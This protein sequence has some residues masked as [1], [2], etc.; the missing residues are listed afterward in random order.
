MS[1][2]KDR[3][4]RGPVWVA[5]STH[6]HKELVAISNLERQGYDVY[7]PMIRRRIRH[8]RRLQEVLRPL[9]PGYVFIQL[10][11]ERDHWRTVLSTIGVKA[12]IRFGNRL[13]IV[14]RGFVEML[15]DHEEDGAVSPPPA[16]E[17]YQPGERVRLREGPFEGL[18]GTV[19]RSDDCDRLTLLMELLCRSVRVKA[20]VDDVAPALDRFSLVNGGAKVGIGSGPVI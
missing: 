9:F 10:D 14:P 20:T 1:I 16:R 12:L 15:K 13:G 8:A 19:L 3:A 7:C 5:V 4:P 11:P 2:D 6:C 18:V 17:S